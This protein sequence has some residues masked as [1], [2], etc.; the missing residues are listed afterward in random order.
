MR[1]I[2]ALCGA[3]YRLGLHP[4]D[5]TCARLSEARREPLLRTRRELAEGLPGLLTRWMVGYT[6]PSVTPPSGG[7]REPNWQAP[8]S[9]LAIQFR[10]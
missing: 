5:L 8:H 6:A 4:P 9:P 10:S 2:N 3:E 7:S 1:Q